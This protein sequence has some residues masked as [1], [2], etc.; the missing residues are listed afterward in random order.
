M[1]NSLSRLTACSSSALFRLSKCEPRKLSKVRQVLR[2]WVTIKEPTRELLNRCELT[3]CPGA[4]VA[5]N[6]L[7]SD[8]A[9][10]DQPNFPEH[11][12]MRQVHRNRV[13]VL[14]QVT[15]LDILVAGC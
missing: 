1:L 6:V 14:A 9:C 8:I 4:H 11:A 12:V 15:K 10:D 3:R 13:A 5:V 7:D 2:A